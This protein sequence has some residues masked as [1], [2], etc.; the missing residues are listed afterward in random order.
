METEVK[1]NDSSRVGQKIKDQE[2][3][4]GTD[5]NC[6]QGRVRGAAGEGA[7]VGLVGGGRGVRFTCILIGP[8]PQRTFI[9]FFNIIA[10]FP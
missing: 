2:I 10:I 8:S 3:P 7:Q 9:S 5:S 6:S 4:R 1:T